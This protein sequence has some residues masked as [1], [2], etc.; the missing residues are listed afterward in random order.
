[1]RFTVGSTANQKLQDVKFADSKKAANAE[2]RRIMAEESAR[3]ADPN[4]L[5]VAENQ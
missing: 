2:P 1:L 4:D 5:T 3:Q